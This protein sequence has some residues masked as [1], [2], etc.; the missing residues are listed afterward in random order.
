MMNEK[1]RP[2]VGDIIAKSKGYSMVLYDFYV[3]TNITEKT[4]FLQK[5]KK[6]NHPATTD[7]FRPLVVPVPEMPIGR[8]ERRA[9]TS[10]YG[11]IWDG[12]PCQ[13]DHL[14]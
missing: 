8:V 1:P 11:D 10:Y 9:L 5:V 12:K 6:I 14:D 13:E 3:V 7:G 4:I 2:H